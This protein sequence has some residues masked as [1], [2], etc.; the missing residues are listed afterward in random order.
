MS[1]G[2]NVL[3]AAAIAC[4]P[5]LAQAATFNIFADSG[6]V[7]TTREQPNIQAQA[8]ALGN[9]LASAFTGTDDASWIA[10]TTGVDT[11]LLPEFER[12][13]PS[14]DMSATA[15][16][17]LTSF[18]SNGGNLVISAAGG[19][20]TVGFLNDV[21]GFSLVRDY[22]GS[23]LSL[24]AAAAGGTAFAPGPASLPWA[25]GTYSVLASSLPTGALNLYTDGTGTSV[26][27]VAY[28][29][30]NI[31]YLG[32]DWFQSASEAGW[33]QV[34][35]ISMNL[36]TTPATVPLPA[37]ALLLLGGLGGLGAARRRVRR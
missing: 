28:G 13:N 24:N 26:F 27:S 20:Q 2:R 37:S 14:G 35:D 17:A 32:F 8:I 31:T 34:L 5:A 11:I 23:A 30:G 15:K 9:T 16:G 7:D 18:V 6:Y 4:A 12:G 21:F 25:N 10:A 3:M 19:S 22:T 33:G 36:A 29:G 1:Y